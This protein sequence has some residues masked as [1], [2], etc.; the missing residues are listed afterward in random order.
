MNEFLIHG[1][2]HCNLAFLS[3]HLPHVHATM[4]TD[5]EIN[6]TFPNNLQRKSLRINFDQAFYQDWL[7]KLMILTVRL[8]V[9]QLNMKVK[10]IK[11]PWGDVELG[12]TQA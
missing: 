4:L 1:I 7:L 10:M 5:D 9:F 12:W 2:L 3:T 8:K 11:P 6:E